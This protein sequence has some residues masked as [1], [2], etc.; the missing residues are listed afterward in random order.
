MTPS[1]ISTPLEGH[2]MEHSNGIS[3]LN[4]HLNGAHL[5]GHTNGYTRSE[6]AASSSEDVLDLL[7]VGF[8][9]A[10][11]AIA[12]ALHDANIAQPPKAL[13]LE[14]QHQFAWH[15][16]MQLPGA[17]MQISFLKDLATPRD[18]RSKFTFLNYL[19]DQG[20][21]NQF[22][23]LG[24]FLPSRLEYED[25]LRWCAAHFER[26]GQVSYGM[27]VESVNV[28]E[29]NSQGQ[30][31]S[32]DVTAR[33]E[34][35]GLV[36]RRARHV[37]IAV[38]GRPVIPPNMQ[39]LK[40]V[41]HSS[42]FAN[43]IGRIQEREVGRK[44]RF[45]VI[46][47]G[48]SAAEIFND[49]WSRFPDASVKLIIKGASLRPSD[50][51][52]FV[53]EIFDPDRV[54]GIYAQPSDERGAALALDRGTN[55]G[56]VRLTLLEHIYEQ[57]YMQR[58]TTPSESQWR[59]RII[60]NRTVIS[61]TQ[62]S[63]SGV[64]LKLADTIESKRLRGGA[65]EEELEVDYVFTA[66]GYVRNAHEGMLSE[67]RDL[68]PSGADGKGEVKWDVGRDYRIKFQ[69]GAVDERAGVWL[70]GCNEK[71]HGLSDTLLSILSIRGGELVESMFG[72][73]AES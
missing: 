64:L 43:T 10:S 42:Q 48:Q 27:A 50:D 2:E 69:E 70:Q 47:S 24:T 38:G 54:D 17:K 61:A 32:W 19:F 36:T 18:P 7:C 6:M 33:S 5:N 13:F 25:Y 67:V 40:H 31:T 37:V 57:L 26:D 66:T 52:P 14:K 41:A 35:G 63:N 29:K 8:G 23:N 15:A 12:I 21:L 16:G 39:G 44:L 11:L 20:R 72:E 1:A 3:S 9:P 30:V 45:A 68:L 71:T 65:G 55:Y 53:N 34:N 56:V 46:G 58:L 51:S 73:G 22:I 28:A 49:L 60:P 62:A 4:K 59:A